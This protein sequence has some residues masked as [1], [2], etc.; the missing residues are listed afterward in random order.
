MNASENNTTMEYVYST[1]TKWG[2]KRYT[3]DVEY[4]TEEP[5]DDLSFVV[6][7]ILQTHEGEYDKLSMG[8]LLGF[9]LLNISSNNGQTA[10][11]DAAEESLFNELLKKVEAEHL[12]TID[13]D[14]IVLTALG[15]VSVTKN[16]HYRFYKGEQGIFEHLKLKTNATEEQLNFPFYKDMGLCTTIEHAEQIWPDDKQIEHIIKCEPTSLI[17]RIRLNSREFVHVYQASL[18][19]YFDIDIKNVEIRLYQHLSGYIPVVVGRNGIAEKATHL[20]NNGLNNI[21]KENLILECLFQKLWDDKSAVLNDM[22]L[23]RYYDLVDFE[24]LVK[25][26]RTQWTDSKLVAVIFDHANATCWKGISRYCDVEVLYQNLSD[27]ADFID[28]SILSIRVDDVFLTKEFLSY[29]WDLE[30]ISQDYDRN[31]EVIEQLITIQKKTEE[32]WNWEE[33]EK[34]L[35]DG[36][37]LSHLNIVNVNLAKFTKDTDEVRTAILSHPEKRWDWHLV[38]TNFDLSFLLQSINVI[39]EHLCF[40]TLLDRVF[41]DSFWAIKF[42]Q[43]PAFN[44][45]LEKA[46]MSNGVLSSCVLNDK[47]YVWCDMVIDCLERVGLLVWE[48]TP[49][50]PGFECNP[51]LIWDEDFFAKYSNKI[52]SEVGCSCV[53]KHIS[54]VEILKSNPNWPWDWSALSANVSLLEDRSLYSLF[55]NKLDWPVVFNHYKNHEFF[56][57]IEDIHIFL[58]DDEEAWTKFSSIAS[59]DYVIQKYKELQFPWNWMVLTERMLP[60]LKLENLGNSIFIDKWDWNLLSGKLPT[61][62]IFCHLATYGSYWNWNVVF[63]HILNERNKTDFDVL[64]DIALKLSS[65]DIETKKTAWAALTSKYCFKDLKRLLTES[66]NRQDY[67]WDMK[68]FCLHEE[69]DIFKDLELCRNLIDWDILSSSERTHRSFTFNPKTGIKFDA[70]KKEI[71]SLLNDDRNHWNYKLLS[72]FSSLQNQQWFLSRYKDE[73][74]WPIISQE[75]KIFCEK[76]KQKLNE[77]IEKY[78]S[79]IDFKLLSERNDI[80]IRQIVKI[81]PTGN[82]DYNSLMKK[83]LIDISFEMVDAKRDYPWDWYELTSKENLYP[84]ASFLLK[85]LDEHINWKFLSCQNNQGLW[86]QADFISTIATDRDISRQVD[87]W[88]ISSRAYFPLVTLRDLPVDSLNWKV[89]SARND[90]YEYLQTYEDYLNWDVLSRNIPI[91]KLDL[92]F[93]KKYENKLNWNEICSNSAF[94]IDNAILELF[95]SHI[96]WNIASASLSIKFSKALI[97]RHKDKWNWPIL[98]KNKA[99][100][101]KIHIDRLSYTDKSNII[102]FIKHFPKTPKAYHFTHMDNALKIIRSM[103]LQSRNL[104]NSSFSNSAGTIVSRTSKAHRFARFYF[105][106]NSP[107]QF[108]NE[109]LGKDTSDYYYQR[110][111]H[112]GLPKCPMPVFL[113]FDVEEILMAMPDKCYYSNGNMQKDASRS[114]KVIDNPNMIRA[115]EIY[116]NSP[117]TKDER[118]QEFLIDG[119]LDFSHLNKVQIRCY[120]EYQA[121]TLRKELAG[122][123]WEDCIEVDS[124]LYGYKN[125]ELLFRDGSDTICISTNYNLPY[126]L[127]VVY[128]NN[129]PEI[130]NQHNV[131]RQ[132]GNNIYLSQSAEISKDSPFEVYFEV[133]SPRHGC[134]LVYQNK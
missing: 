97:E 106:P 114:F 67:W 55:G 16:I 5:L 31:I 99:F 80:D 54:T 121:A 128:T 112:L 118:Q 76:D 92:E 19:E 53:S 71:E 61:D 116:I 1:F 2:L 126:E 38:E 48:S 13:N 110:A 125:K 111:L 49:Y 62:F 82:Y 7:S 117:Y 24:E 56:E 103:K 113:I 60:I 39:E 14:D 119:E 30:V 57:K 95:P 69:F 65:L 22:S 46:S 15:K 93:L 59:V 66:A 75:S 27:I 86:R 11:Y 98:I 34:R 32:D 23:N 36:F 130:I 9:S 107:T 94:H 72:H 40:S 109:C 17:E 18:Q 122:T 4:F 91:E 84:K 68:I 3:C 129:A 43:H 105:V 100:Y 132:K 133:S 123:K 73:V 20:V 104:V 26:S 74:D 120:D 63:S 88:T 6:C 21:Q 85:H 102:E 44:S 37:V 96:D 78:K 29:P 8:V 79:L 12:I 77:I 25:D 33:L 45:A 35:F 52:V 41:T 127:R 64:D 42:A 115:K 90:I 58:A 50:M 10:Y 87:W 70:W 131:L 83:D 134:W 108:Y 81:Y 89:L 47:D 28:W 124:S 101:N 51:N